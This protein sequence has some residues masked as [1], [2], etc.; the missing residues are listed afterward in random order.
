M[1]R[2][3]ARQQLSPQLTLIPAVFCSLLAND[4]EQANKDA[5]K[6]AWGDRG[7]GKLKF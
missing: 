7:G 4:L 6:T 5:I 1:S 2:G 3:R